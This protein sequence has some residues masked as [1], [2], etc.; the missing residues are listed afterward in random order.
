M[1]ERAKSTSFRHR[2]LWYVVITA[3]IQFLLGMGFAS[4]VNGRGPISL[5]FLIPMANFA[6]LLLMLYGHGLSYTQ[7]GTL[8]IAGT[9]FMFLIVTALGE[10][11]H[12][13][14]N[15]GKGQ[16]ASKP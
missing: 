2:V 1:N 4:T 3:V 13:L 12:Q 14:Y 15:S 8:I 10:I 16:E 11:H 9:F 5:M 6:Y 7:Y